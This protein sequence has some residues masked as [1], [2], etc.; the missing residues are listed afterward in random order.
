V[1]G[2]SSLPAGANVSHGAL[3]RPGARAPLQLVELPA[4][5]GWQHKSLPARV[6]RWIEEF[7][8]VPTGY[9]AGEP[10]RLSGFQRQIIEALYENRTTIASLPAGN[11]KTTLLGSIALERICRGDDYV[12]VDIVATKQ[13]QAGILVETAKRMVEA[14][15]ALVPLCAFSANSGT[16]DY[17]VT[18]SRIRAQPAKLSAVQ[19]LNFSLAIIDEIGFA[20]DHV[21]STL[22]ARLGKR[23]DAALIGIGTPGIA[24][25]VMF[26]LRERQDELKAVGFSYLEW[27]APAGCSVHDRKAW[28]KAN[29]AIGAGFL[30]IEAMAT[31][32][33]VMPEHEFR[34]YH[35]GQFVSG[36]SLSSWLPAG[37]WAMC[38]RAVSPP[39]GA[40]VVLA[41]AG[42]WQSGSVA[43]VGATMD[44]ELF[45]AWGADAATDDQLVE[46]FDQA[47]RRWRVVEVVAAP[48]QR[49]GLIPRLVDA[50]LE[51]NVWPA[52]VDVE[53][54]SATEWRRAI[55]E[56][57]VAHDHHPLLAEH[58]SATVARSTADGSLR[59]SPPDD[60]SP[61]DAARA[62][63]MAWWRALDVGS[64]YE[65]A[66]VF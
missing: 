39:G 36:E 5:H 59:L 43:V 35:L 45:L 4:W 2:A 19:G 3:S 64:R 66:G 52:T 61:V 57:R 25:N 27:A 22:M 29:P 17:R 47:A 38:P 34:V 56:G 48:R 51:V 14:S 42:T 10:M 46:V 24:Q 41:L 6:C 65:P 50:G 12:E 49:S 60:G 16:L 44:G 7:V 26:R 28:R 15:P 31:Q 20:E 18:G 32:A 53:V 55:V 9:G 62:A 58:V 1:R 33:A 8:V 54:S 37:A 11:G 30:N 13:D 63:R 23:P 21:V 40:E